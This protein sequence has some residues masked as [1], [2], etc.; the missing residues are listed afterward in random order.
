MGEG[1]NIMS[2][3]RKE[4]LTTWQIFYNSTINPSAQ[5][6]NNLMPLLEQCEAIDTETWKVSKLH[7]VRRMSLLKNGY[8]A[9]FEHLLEKLNSL[10]GEIILKCLGD[11]PKKNDKDK[12]SVYFVDL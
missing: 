10:M 1:K 11:N 2:P 5:V 8:D 4:A 9:H 6:V 7:F 3:P 12:I